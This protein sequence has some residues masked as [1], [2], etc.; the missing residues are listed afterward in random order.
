METDFKDCSMIPDST[1]IGLA[2]NRSG[3]LAIYLPCGC[4]IG[5][6]DTVINASEIAVEVR[7]HDCPASHQHNW[8]QAESPCMDC[9]EHGAIYCE[10]CDTLRDIIYDDE[11]WSIYY[12]LED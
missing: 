8:I 1:V 9:G 6:F 12:S 2:S 11:A 4:E 10:S 5:V 7:N 3:D